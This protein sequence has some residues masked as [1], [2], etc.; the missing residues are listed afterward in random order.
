MFWQSGQDSPFP[1][2]RAPARQKN[3][4]PRM[5][6]LIVWRLSVFCVSSCGAVGSSGL[7]DCGFS[8]HT[9]LLFG[10]LTHSLTRAFAAHTT[11]VIRVN[12]TKSTYTFTSV[13]TLKLGTQTKIGHSAPPDNGEYRDHP[14][15]GR[16][17]QFFCI[18]RL[19]PSIYHSPQK[20]YQE[21]QT[22]QQ[23]I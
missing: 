11:L 6:T 17:S 5:F 18:R 2:P 22:P 13:H 19:G 21:F 8:G 23:N 16:Y 1:P 7:Y 3:M 20:K 12:T 14:R 4:G 9:H 15:G 10:T